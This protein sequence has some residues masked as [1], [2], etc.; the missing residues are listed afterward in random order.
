VSLTCQALTKV[1]DDDVPGKPVFRTVGPAG[2]SERARLMPARGHIL[3]WPAFAV[4]A[5]ILALE[6]S[7]GRSLAFLYAAPILAALSG[8]RRSQV[9]VAAAIATVCAA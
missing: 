3:P 2:M 1:R 4:G 9:F 5:V 7:T 6:L 8:S